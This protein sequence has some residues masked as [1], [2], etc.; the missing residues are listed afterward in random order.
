MLNY[1]TPMG[2]LLQIIKRHVADHL[3]DRQTWQGPDPGSLAIGSQ[4]LGQWS[5]RRSRRDL[6]F[7]LKRQARRFYHLGLPQCRVLP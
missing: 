2:Q 6:L 4:A 3:V 1:S 7:S 5:A